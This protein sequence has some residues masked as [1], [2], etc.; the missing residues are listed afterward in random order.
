MDDPV[1]CLYERYQKE[2]YVYLFRL[3]GNEELAEDLVEET[4]LK[5]LLAL[6]ECRDNLRAWLYRVARNLYFNYRKQELQKQTD[7]LPADRPGPGLSP[8]ESVLGK[9]RTKRVE[10]A[11]ARLP[12]PKA[13]IVRLYYYGKLPYREIAERLSLSETSVRVH[14]CRAKKELK[15]YLEDYYYE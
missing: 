2:L 7:Q 8:A 4:F 11:L 5:A 12:S 1:R 14:C 3:C 13:E 15:K 6:P 10:E 9:E